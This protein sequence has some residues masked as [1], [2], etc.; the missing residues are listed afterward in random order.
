MPDPPG[1]GPALR[2]QGS[3]GGDA[4]TAVG[5]HGERANL[6]RMPNIASHDHGLG[7]T[8]PSG[9][10]LV[11]GLIIALAACT[12]GDAASTPPG[13]SQTL[14]PTRAASSTLPS[15][16]STTGVPE[17]PAHGD[18]WEISEV[19]WTTQAIA[20]Q[21][22]AA[23]A[24]RIV[25]VGGSACAADGSACHGGIWTLSSD[26][27]LEPVPD[28]SNL[29]VGDVHPSSGP[30][31]G[32]FDIAAGPNGFVALGYAAGSG[33]PIQG[34]LWRSNDGIAW[35]RVD[36]GPL[37]DRSRPE[38]IVA[39]GPGYVIVG[40]ADE[41]DAP[42]AAVW[43]SADGHAWVRAPEQDSFDI[44]GYINTGETPGSGGM[45]AVTAR[46]SELMAVGLW[47]AGGAPGPCRTVI[48]RS[49]D[50]S[51]WTRHEPLNIPASGGIAA[52]AANGERFVAVGGNFEPSDAFS[53]T[54]SDGVAFLTTPHP[55]IPRFES[56]VAM[57]NGFLAL[58]SAAARLG[59]W[60][61]P[62]GVEWDAI[63]GVPQPAGATV[64]RELDVTVAGD[65]LIIVGWAETVAGQASFVLTAPIRRLSP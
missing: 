59:V 52:V 42:R 60:T 11:G 9:L 19:P 36:V 39:G 8:I 4:S 20:L 24:D 54:S 12:A 14:A 27:A 31:P 41:L 45:R 44:G 53:V 26:G 57:P 1:P 22:A 25:V 48:W 18:A 23:T 65:Q 62:D 33:E 55:T 58:T 49:D 2:A 16:S 10:I 61:S 32:L 46:G 40:E 64:L 3:T 15:S 51:G 63:E 50:A 21:A 13:E 35:E 38:M 47:C 28:A 29:D 7:G 5:P 17:S 56:V 37:L 34:A 30:V 43:S 6:C